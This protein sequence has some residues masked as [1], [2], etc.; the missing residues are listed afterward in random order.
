MIVIEVLRIYILG[1]CGAGM[2]FVFTHVIR[3]E[4]KLKLYAGPQVLIR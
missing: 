1:S 4:G 3:G 2:L